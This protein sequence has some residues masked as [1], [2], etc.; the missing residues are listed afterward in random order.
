MKVN[1]GWRKLGWRHPVWDMLRFYSVV[2]AQGKNIAAEWRRKF[3]GSAVLEVDASNTFPVDPK[4]VRLFCRYLD[5]QATD[6]QTANAVLRDEAA[7]IA[8]AE[9]VKAKIRVIA[10]QS[11]DHHQSSAATVAAVSFLAEKVC[12]AKGITCETAP[13]RRC[14]CTRTDTRRRS[15]IQRYW[16]RE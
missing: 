8:F 4:H 12:K 7:A 16:C 5:Q 9:G 11:A 3:E 14:P 10:T 1:A 15:A 2:R 6:L 13:S